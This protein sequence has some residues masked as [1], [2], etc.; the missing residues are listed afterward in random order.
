M[1]ILLVVTKGSMGGAQKRVYDLACAYEEAGH[2]VMIALG[3]EGIFTEKLTEEGKPFHLF[4]HLERSHSIRAILGFV[5]EMMLYISKEKPDIVH[6]NSSNTLPG[7]LAAKLTPKKKRPEVVFT[8]RG[9]SMLDPSAGTR[10]Y[11][12]IFYKRYF[13]FFL[14]FVDKPVFQCARNMID[15]TNMR[16]VKK[17]SIIYPGI[18]FDAISFLSRVNARFEMEKKLAVSFDEKFILG[19]VG[20]LSDEKNHRFL[21]ERFW[22]ILRVKENTV[23]VLIGD[24]PN[25]KVLEA[26]VKAM[27]LEGKVYFYGEVDDAS[28]LLRGLDMF[29]LPSHFE[30]V[31]VAL[32]EAL[33]AGLPILASDVGGNAE[34]IYGPHSAVCKPRD[35]HDFIQKFEAL[36]TDE[37]IQKEMDETIDEHVDKFRLG[38]SS[39]KYLELYGK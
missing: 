15:A 9:L 36:L 29:V 11:K 1:K 22:E 35:S 13:K 3:G 31:S 4:S 24:G 14:S 21:I 25:R 6:L 19:T 26:L 16:L 32:T 12:R 18:D 39:Q 37:G 2:E 30:G 20:R 38:N 5:F 17:G 7:A 23:L 27:E 8:F 10:W 33:I 34:V 28:T